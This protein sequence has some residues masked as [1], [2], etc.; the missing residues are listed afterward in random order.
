VYGE[1]NDGPNGGEVDL[2]A[3]VYVGRAPV[4]SHRELSNFVS[5][6]IGYEQ[7]SGQGYLE[8]VWMVGEL[9]WEEGGCAL[10]RALGESDVTDPEGVLV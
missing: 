2:M 9:L 5:K 8:E 4:D 10:E 6:T 1:P 7:S 3:E